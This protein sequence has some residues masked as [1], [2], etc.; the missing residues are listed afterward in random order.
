MPRSRP[1]Q[2]CVERNTATATD[3][4]ARTLRE[5]CACGADHHTI[6]NWGPHAKYA[7]LMCA[8][9]LGETVAIAQSV[10]APSRRP[11]SAASRVAGGCFA[12]RLIG[13]QVD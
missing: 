1:P 6:S 11:A 5:C 9:P 10:D 2:V 3:A 8:R 13:T 4:F 12:A 7:V